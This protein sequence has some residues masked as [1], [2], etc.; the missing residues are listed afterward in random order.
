MARA[1][2][3]TG[4]QCDQK[5]SPPA[6]CAT[7]LAAVYRGQ[8][9]LK[10]GVTVHENGTGTLSP[11]VSAE[12]RSHSAIRVIG[13]RAMACF[14]NCDRPPGEPGVWPHIAGG[15]QC[16]QVSIAFRFRR[17]VGYKNTHHVQPEWLAAQQL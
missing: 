15:Q 4:R 5:T 13:K 8:L 3:A 2:P 9:P 12:T 10:Y 7:L 17:L 6:P 1:W 16:M 11:D 14:V